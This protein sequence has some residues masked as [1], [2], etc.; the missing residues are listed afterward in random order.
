[1]IGEGRQGPIL[2]VRSIIADYRSRHPETVPR[3]GRRLKTSPL[4]PNAAQCTADNL[5]TS[6][7]ATGGILNMASLALGSG[8]HVRTTDL[9]TDPLNY[10]ISTFQEG[11][12]RPSSADSSRSVPAGATNPSA[13]PNIS[14]KDVLVQFAKLSQTAGE[15]LLPKNLVHQQQQQPV[16]PPPPPPPYPEVTLHPVAHSPPPPSSSLLHGILTKSTAARPQEAATQQVAQI[17]PGPRPT[18]TFSPTLARL[19]TAPERITNSAAFMASG[20]V[21][22]NDLLTTSSKVS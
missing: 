14:F 3:R 1:M 6:S 17:P 8:C 11:P 10:L 7:R 22:L 13:D 15:N 5:V 2:D 9:G 20:P 16:P 18:T 19:L 4:S 12:S 21:S